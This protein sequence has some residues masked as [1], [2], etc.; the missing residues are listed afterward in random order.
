MSIIISI[1]PGQEGAVA[2]FQD[3]VLDEIFD[4]P[5][6][7]VITKEMIPKFKHKNPKILI[8][9]G[10]NKGKRQTVTRTPAKYEILYDIKDLYKRFK[11]VK[12]YIDQINTNAIVYVE[13]QQAGRN[14]SVTVKSLA[15]YGRILGAAEIVFGYENLETVSAN[16]WKR[17]FNLTKRKGDTDKQKKDRSIK[18]ARKLFDGWDFKRHDL[19]EAALIGKFYLEK[20]EALK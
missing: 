10:K 20:S 12:K 1:D 9:S 18:L 15:N 2:V 19:A 7:K 14:Q 17:H 13:Q 8:K 3:G 5:V 11:S 4:M 16:Q 6:R